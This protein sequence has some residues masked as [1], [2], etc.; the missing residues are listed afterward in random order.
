M[1]N[2][3]IKKILDGCRLNKRRAQKRLY[4]NY[5][6]HAM[7]IAFQ[8]S[9][10][11]EN[12]EKITNE[13]FLHIYKDLTNSAPRPDISVAAFTASLEKEIQRSCLDYCRKYNLQI[14]ICRRQFGID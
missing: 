1:T 7:S 4:C 2:R 3:Q 13:A 6:G 10:D 9:F 14:P 8:Y 11:F 12:A 5:Y